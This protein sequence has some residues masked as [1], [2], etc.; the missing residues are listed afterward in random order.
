V[1]YYYYQRFMA[2]RIHEHTPELPAPVMDKLLA[3]D[4]GDLDLMIKHPPALEGQ[5]RASA[6]AAAA[7][8]GGTWTS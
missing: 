1:Q 7:A 8:G 6:S 4:A 3:M 5:V 2:Q